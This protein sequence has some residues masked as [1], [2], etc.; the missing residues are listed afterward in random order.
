MDLALVSLF[1]LLAVPALE[2]LAAGSTVRFLIAIPLLVFLP[3]YAC[4]AMLFPGTA[5][6]TDPR[7]TGLNRG[8]DSVERAGLSFGLSLGI[9]PLVLIGVGSFQP[10]TLEIVLGS[11][12]LLTLVL[13]QVALLRRL[14][15]PPNER[16]TVE[17]LTWA[18]TMYARTFTNRGFAGQAAALL[19]VVG[20]VVGFGTIAVAVANPPD[21]NAFT[22]FYVGTENEEGDL[23]TSGYPDTIDVDDSATLTFAVENHEQSSQQYFVVVQLQRVEDGEVV[24]RDRLGSFDET[25]AAGETWQ[26]TNELSPQR[27]GDDL[28]ITYLLYRS[29]P[30][31]EPT[32]ENAYRHLHIWIEVVS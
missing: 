9:V 10:L 27:T 25:V 5:E 22:E 7:W 15:V 18:R 31:E 4:L 2:L 23:V 14:Q 24:A 12:A 20:V 11:L 32:K 17:P 13:T 28:R 3:G 26:R 19:L 16:Y 30:P 1:V 6:S 21:A 29:E 8:L